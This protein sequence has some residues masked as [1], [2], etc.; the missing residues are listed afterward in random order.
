MVG[1]I[2]PNRAG[3][4]R[5]RMAAKTWW[6]PLR[7][8]WKSVKKVKKKSWLNEGNG[9]IQLGAYEKKK[10]I[11]NKQKVFN[12]FLKAKIYEVAKTNFGDHI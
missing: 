10:S 1:I 6:E 8:P 4:I 7:S 5:V 2:Y 11:C 3:K 12:M 9:Q